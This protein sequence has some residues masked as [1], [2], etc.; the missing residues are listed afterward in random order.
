MIA[1]SDPRMVHI[2]NAIYAAFEPFKIG[3]VTIF[4]D[5]SIGS[6]QKI[7]KIRLKRFPNYELRLPV[8]IRHIQNDADIVADRLAELAFDHYRHKTRIEPESNVSLAE[9]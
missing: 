4:V 2:L 8:D 5:E 3:E 1:D 9:N 7:F 6:G